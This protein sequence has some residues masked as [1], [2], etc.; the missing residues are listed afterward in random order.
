MKKYLLGVAIAALMTTPAMAETIGVSM[1]ELDNFL[2][3]LRNGIDDDAKEK[4]VEAAD[5][6]GRE[7]SGQA[8]QPDPELHRLG[9]RR[10]HHQPGRHRRHAR[11]SRSSR[12]TPAFRWSTST[13]QPVNL[14]TLPDNQTF[15]GSN[16]VDSGT[17]ET[18]EICRLLK[19]KGKGAAPTS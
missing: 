14:D 13:A 3:V 2:T 16:E 12:R 15:V 9:R 8:A 11:R 17:L 4:G 1:S 6:S 19:D 5:R 18:K 7:G 10:D